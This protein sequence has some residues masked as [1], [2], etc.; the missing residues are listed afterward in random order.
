MT[1]GEIVTDVRGFVNEATASYFTPTILTMKVNQ[2]YR[3]AQARV[4]SIRSTE[5]R[6]RSRTNIVANQERYVRATYE[7]VVAYQ[8]LDS[9]SGKYVDMEELK[10]EQLT[11]DA[12]GSPNRS[13][14]H[15]R[16]TYFVDG[17]DIVLVPTPSASV[18]DGLQCLYW[19]SVGLTLDGSVPRLPEALHP[20]LAFRAAW[21]CVQDTK[22]AAADV[23]RGWDREWQSVFGD[24][25]AA[26]KELA[27][28]YPQTQGTRINP[29]VRWPTRHA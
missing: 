6:A 19:E 5:F 17:A 15:V 11:G 4:R 18:T 8:I 28:H 3:S 9:L 7:P 12:N 22:D 27:R 23:V 16:Q 20:Y 14:T 13:A 24:S 1:K 26:A 25:E 2:S 10:G 29:G 21:L